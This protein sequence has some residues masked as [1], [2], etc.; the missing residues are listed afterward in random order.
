MARQRSREARQRSIP[1]T[2]GTPGLAFQSDYGVRIDFQRIANNCS[3]IKRHATTYVGVLLRNFSLPSEGLSVSTLVGG[4]RL[5][6]M[7]Y[8]SNEC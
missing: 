8:E 4:A 2:P 1:V 6:Y 7:L 3:R 5:D